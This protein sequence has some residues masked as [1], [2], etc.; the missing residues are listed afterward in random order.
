[1]GNILQEAHVTL[2]ELL[3][4]HQLNQELLETSTMTLLWLK[5]NAEKN[6]I[7]FPNEGSLLSLVNKA[8]A[9]IDEITSNTNFGLTLKSSDGS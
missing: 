6:G 2:G 8:E 3:R 5:D 1:M 7:I 9:L 4:M